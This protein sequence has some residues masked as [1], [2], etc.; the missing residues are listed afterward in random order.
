MPG[1]AS[2]LPT[3]LA[4]A[5]DDVLE[6][7]QLAHPNRAA[8]VQ[9][10]GRVAD[11]GPHPVLEAIGEAGRGVDVDRLRRGGDD[12]LRVPGAVGVYVLDRFLNR[13][14]DRDR[15]LQPQ[16]LGVPVLLAG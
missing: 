3:Y 14:D 16:E 9:L 15:Q 2:A 5:V 12:R 6:R 10:L 11:L 1:P 7:G 8:G 4:V 13:V